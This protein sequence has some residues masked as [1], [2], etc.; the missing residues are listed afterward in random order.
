VRQK[1][2]VLESP[3]HHPPDVGIHKA[4]NSRQYRA[5]T[6]VELDT[7][8][9]AIDILLARGLIAPWA[10]NEKDGDYVGLDPQSRPWQ[11]AAK[12]AKETKEEIKEE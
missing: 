1:F 4:E 6:I 11:R 10:G 12:A 5:G 9:V 3:L 7:E 2:V 8:T